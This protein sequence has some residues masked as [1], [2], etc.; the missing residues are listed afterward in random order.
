MTDLNKKIKKITLKQ[1]LQNAMGSDT[2]KKEWCVP[3]AFEIKYLRRKAGLTQEQLA[4]KSGL[5]QEAIS[6]LENYSDK[7]TMK[8]IGKVA[9][10]LGY[11]AK[12]EFEKL[13]NPK[14]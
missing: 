1:V 3:D 7:T 2:F 12:I 14:R 11:R 13:P 5:K 4:K 9:Y 8:T 6:R 10:A